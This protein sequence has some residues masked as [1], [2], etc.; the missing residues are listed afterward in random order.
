MYVIANG[1]GCGGVVVGVGVLLAAGLGAA[2][3]FGVAAGALWGVGAAELA[4][5]A[6]GVSLAATWR[7]EVET[8]GLALVTLALSTEPPPIA[9]WYA[10]TLPATITAVTTAVP[11][12]ASSLYFAI[13]LFITIIK[14][15]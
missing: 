2:L 9:P 8:F 6:A 5:E 15:H 12:T 7:G 14:P 13:I 10:T 11:T 3:A 1:P 4:G